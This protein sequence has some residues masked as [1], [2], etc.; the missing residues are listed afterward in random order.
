M[1]KL[2]DVSFAY[3]DTR[4]TP[5]YHG[6]IDGI[7][8]ELKPGQL[9]SVVGCTGTGKT[10]LLR[11]IAGYLT[12]DSGSIEWQ[13]KAVREPSPDRGVVFQQNALFPWLTVAENVEFG[14]K[15]QK[16]RSAERKKRVAEYLDMLNLGRYAAALLFKVSAYDVMLRVSLARCLVLDPG[17]MIIDDEPLGELDDVARTKLQKLLLNIWEAKGHTMIMATHDVDEALVLSS[18]V[19]VMGGRP[20]RIVD[21]FQT[22]FAPRAVQEGIEAVRRTSAFSDIRRSILGHI[23]A[24][25]DK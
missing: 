10:T 8:L 12:P 15:M 9:M 13:G 4:I 24:P 19:V 5:R 23:V 1:L 2:Q 3:A 16:V 18:E 14:L 11:L 21:R 7:S 6:D 25:I 20:G 17:L 22:S